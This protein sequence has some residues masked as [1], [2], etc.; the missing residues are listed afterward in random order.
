MHFDIT[1]VFN[2]AQMLQRVQ[3]AT[4]SKRALGTVRHTSWHKAIAGTWMSELQYCAVKYAT[5]H[6]R[7]AITSRLKNIPELDRLKSLN[8]LNYCR[9]N[10]YASVARTETYNDTISPMHI[11]RAVVIHRLYLFLFTGPSLHQSLRCSRT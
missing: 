8:S 10:V 3:I 2:N 11:R 7:I 5:N 6:G 1:T 4:A 9:F